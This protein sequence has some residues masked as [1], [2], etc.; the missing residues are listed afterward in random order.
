M[1]G[2]A[3]LLAATCSGIG[4][5]E[6]AMFS[7]HMLSHM[8]EGVLAP[9]LL[10]Q[11]APLSLA[12][13]SARPGDAG[14]STATDWVKAMMESRCIRWVTH[15]LV[16]LVMFAGAPYVIY[17]SSVFDAVARFHWAHMLLAAFFL[18][19]G[20]LFAWSTIG[21]DQAPSPLPDM[22]RLGMLLAAGPCTAVFAAW[23]VT[24]NRLLGDG[25]AGYNAY[26]SLHL[27]W[28][29]DLRGDQWL[30]GVIALAVGETA[31]LGALVVLL[32]RW[33]PWAAAPGPGDFG[34]RPRGQSPAEGSP[35]PC[36][37]LL[38]RVCP[39]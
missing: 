17:F 6:P 20:Y 21:V 37:E 2:C 4:R 9:G 22:A 24:T 28:V 1:M 18:V 29:V 16:A 26:S 11:G 38:A 15:P 10:V 30:G 12:I 25:P 34:R 23:V 8:L 27:P 39:D 35:E 33:H 32:A 13:A 36:T 5:Y 14:L 19:V 31:L 7:M 3:V